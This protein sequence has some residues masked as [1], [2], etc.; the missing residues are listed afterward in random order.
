[1]SKG[2][3]ASDAVIV[4]DIEQFLY[5]EARLLDD[6]KFQEWLELITDDVRYW[7]PVM[8]R[9]YRKG[10]KGMKAL[11]KDQYED[12]EFSTEDELAI[13]DDT[14]DSLERRVARLDTGM[15][16]AEDPPSRTQRMISNV[17]V[18]HGDTPS[19]MKVNS[20]FILYRTRGDLEEDFYVGSRQDVL[21]SEGGKWKLS[22]RKILLPQN[23]LSSKNASSFF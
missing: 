7:M 2:C 11:D 3:A 17:T 10:S 15:A 19:E 9:R 8:G 22:Y 18:G 21:R 6:C 23:V 20:N 1:M 14:K 4:H 5:Q 16:W 13:F 12:R